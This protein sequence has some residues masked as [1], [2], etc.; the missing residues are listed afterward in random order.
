MGSGSWKRE[1]FH[2]Y[3]ASR[4]EKLD[5]TDRVVSRMNIQERYKEREI[6]SA[7]N[8]YKIMRE[9]RDTDEHPETRPVIIGLDVTGSMSDVLEETARCIGTVMNN[10]MSAG[11]TIPEAKDVEFCIAAYGDFAY[12]SAPVQFSQFE[13]DTRIVEHLDKVY[14]ERGGGGNAFESTTVIWYMG[15]RH[16]DLDCWKRGRKGLIITIGDEECP[17][18]LPKIPLANAT[19]DSLQADVLTKD[20][21]AEASRKYE[22]HHIHVLHRRQNPLIRKSWEKSIGEQNYHESEV[23][24]LGSLIT[25]IV[26]SAGK[27]ETSVPAGDEMI[28]W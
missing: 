1:A 26:L 17:P 20:L 7:L 5:A 25:S 27:E 12:D 22:I 2:K 23:N 24:G 14:F 4:G 18:Y 6:N 10:I 3:S 11:E 8:P 16:C 9:C 19:G 13:S 15:T 28:S 21:Y